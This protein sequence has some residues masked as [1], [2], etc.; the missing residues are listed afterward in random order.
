MAIRP[1]GGPE[2]VMELFG[3]VAHE[4]APDAPKVARVGAGATEFRVT[5]RLTLPGARARLTLHGRFPY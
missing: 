1:L 5:P 2:T 4:F 3:P